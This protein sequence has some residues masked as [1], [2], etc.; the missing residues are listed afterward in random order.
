MVSVPRLKELIH[1]GLCGRPSLSVSMNLIRKLHLDVAV[2]INDKRCAR[3][4]PN[5]TLGLYGRLWRV[6]R[7]HGNCAN[8]L[9]CLAANAAPYTH[10]VCSPL[11]GKMMNGKR[12]LHMQLTRKLSQDQSLGIRRQVFK[13]C[14]EPASQS[15]AAAMDETNVRKL[16]NDSA[17][18]RFAFGK[19]AGPPP[20]LCLKSGSWPQGQ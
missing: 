1:E 3:R 20:A 4:P 2:A 7:V 11:S 5:P 15:R 14:H 9:I 19:L 17:P 13:F 6:H 18:V 10:H 12:F 16:D 8:T